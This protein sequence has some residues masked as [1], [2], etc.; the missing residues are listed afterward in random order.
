MSYVDM[1]KRKHPISYRWTAFKMRLG[2]I[3]Y[4]IKD[5]EMADG[6]TYR[7]RRIVNKQVYRDWLIEELFHLDNEIQQKRCYEDYKAGR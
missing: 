5:G 7:T 1:V 2:Y 4:W 3:W 6:R